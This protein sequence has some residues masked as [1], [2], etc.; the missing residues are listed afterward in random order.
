VVRFAGQRSPSLQFRG[1]ADVTLSARECRSGPAA[2]GTDVARLMSHTSAR[3][4]LRALGG[5]LAVQQT[6]GLA[7]LDKYS[8]VYF[9]LGVQQVT[10]TLEITGAEKPMTSSTAD[11]GMEPPDWPDIDPDHELTWRQQQILHFIRYYAERRGYMP[12]VREIGEA[13]ELAS[14]SSVSYQLTELQRKGYLRRTPGRPRGIELRLPGQ[15]TV[16]LETQDLADAVDLPF[17]DPASVPVPLYGQIA[18]G[19]QNLTERIIG[20]TWALPIGDT[21]DLPK[22][23]VGDG[24]LFRLRVRGDS[25]INAA[26]ADGDIVVV[27]QQSHA[28]NGDV[29]AAMIDGDTT[30]KTFQRV[31]GQVWLIPHNPAYEPIPWPIPRDDDTIEDATILG[32]VVAVLRRV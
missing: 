17:Q 22:E 12:S 1:R 23:L 5:E 13:A 14:P 31:D 29:V 28:Q 26:I 7:D 25:M 8:S 19:P 3:E 15:P 18:A 16:R 9:N 27:R 11:G 20:D 32:K 4:I 21:W 10:C 24:T 2:S 6:G 30:I